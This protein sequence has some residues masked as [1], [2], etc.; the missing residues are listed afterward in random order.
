M[1]P[2]PRAVLFDLDGTLVDS[3]G[4]FHHAANQMLMQLGYPSIAK[5]YIKQFV[6][7]GQEV[8]IARCLVNV[9]AK[10]SAEELCAATT[11]FETAYDEIS[12]QKSASYDGCRDYLHQLKQANIRIG[13]CTNRPVVRARGILKEL[14]LEAFF[15]VIAGFEST[16]KPK[17][18]PQPLHYC[19]QELSVDAKDAIFIGD[20]EVDA[21]AA[22]AA[23]VPFWFHSAGLG[24]LAGQNAARKFSN[25]RELLNPV[26]A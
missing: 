6:G 4:D 15:D 7:N 21:L 12:G 2:N 8:F 26:P 25:Y 1:Q 10:M 23:G 5:Q 20:S 16:A 19:L 3:L 17:P 9:G 14:G 22:D 11:Y 18:D 24:E 13:L